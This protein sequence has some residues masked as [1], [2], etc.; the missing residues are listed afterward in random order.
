VSEIGRVEIMP[1]IDGRNMTMVLAP[2]RK[3]QAA[4]ER[5]RRQAESNTGE[6]PVVTTDGAESVA[7]EATSNDE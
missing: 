3:A 6:V 2:D 4:A 1:R 5:A 7:S